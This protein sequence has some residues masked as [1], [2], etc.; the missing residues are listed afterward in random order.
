MLDNIK[1]LINKVVGKEPTKS[2]VDSNIGV[3]Y[4]TTDIDNMEGYLYKVKYK[5]KF[6]PLS[7]EDTDI[8]GITTLYSTSFN[9]YHETPVS[10]TVDENY[11]SDLELRHKTIVKTN[12]GRYKELTKVKGNVINEIFVIKEIL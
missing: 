1:D 2:K 12:W 7:H 4:F 6:Y 8:T 9:I 3:I 10:T 5:R 11:Y